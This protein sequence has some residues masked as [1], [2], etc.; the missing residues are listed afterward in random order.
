MDA[1]H[2][3]EKHW[4][5]GVLLPTI[6]SLLIVPTHVFG[7]GRAWQA[8]APAPASG[9]A[10]MTAMA[11]LLS[12]ATNRALASPP[13]AAPAIC[14]G[15]DVGLFPDPDDCACFFACDGFD[16]GIRACCTVTIFWRCFNPELRWCDLCANVG[17]CGPGAQPPPGPKG[18]PPGAPPPGAVPPA[19]TPPATAGSPP[20][21]A[22][23][24]ASHPGRVRIL[25]YWGQAGS[26]E[27]TSYPALSKV[28]GDFDMVVLQSLSL[29]LA[30]Q[31]ALTNL[32]ISPKCTAA[33]TAAAAARCASSDLGL[34]L[35]ECQLQGRLILLGVSQDDSTPFESQEQAI[36]TAD[37]I[38]NLYLAGTASNRPFGQLVLDGVDVQSMGPTPHYP[39]FVQRLWG[40]MDKASKKYYLTATVGCAYPDPSLGAV[41]LQDGNLFDYI[42]V[43]FFDNPNCSGSPELVQFS[44]T[45]HWAPLAK[46]F[47]QS[48]PQLLPALPSS[49]SAAKSGYIN[50]TQTG[51][52]LQQLATTGTLGGFA[53]WNPVADLQSASA[54]SGNLTWSQQVLSSLK[55]GETA[56]D[57]P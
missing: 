8:P 42:A 10:P 39:A 27:D 51:T 55:G 1:I 46:S 57:C 38:W 11:R 14:A 45:K 56:K 3:S 30:K 36:D 26:S 17:T 29:K 5:P 9:G 41:L 33:P 31:G 4:S 19:P 50:A 6:F 40:H 13:A 25:T 34:A 47:S 20:L 18:L 7:A 43:Q 44:Y 32:T 49:P 28:C 2:S 54:S 48:P 23:P 53:V 22:P 16:G 37:G 52:L 35:R 12:E 21:G 24:P 15:K